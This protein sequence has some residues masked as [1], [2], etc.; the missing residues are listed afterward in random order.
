MDDQ[1]NLEIVSRQISIHQSRAVWLYIRMNQLYRAVS[2]SYSDHWTEDWLYASL[3]I[4]ICMQWNNV[5]MDPLWGMSSCLRVVLTVLG[6]NE[7]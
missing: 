7:E 5:A 4:E 1:Q 3:E 6:N 2:R